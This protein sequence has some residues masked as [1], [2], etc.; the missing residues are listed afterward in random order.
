M[1]PSVAY[2]STSK[3]HTISELSVEKRFSKQMALRNKLVY[4][5]IYL[6]K[7]TTNKKQKKTIKRGEK[8]HFMLIKAKET[9]KRRHLNSQHLCPKLK[10]TYISIGNTTKT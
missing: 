6:A 8:G 4:R 7:Y 2:I 10:G 3:I 9:Q 5:F 1:N